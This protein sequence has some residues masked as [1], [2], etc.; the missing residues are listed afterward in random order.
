M[1]THVAK[2]PAGQPTV[3]GWPLG[4]RG[5]RPARFTGNFFAPETKDALGVPGVLTAKGFITCG[6]DA[7]PIVAK[8]LKVDAPV[9]RH[10]TVDDV[11]LMPGFARWKELGLGTKLRGYQKEGALFLAWRAFALNCD[12]M[13][14]GKSAQALGGVVLIASRKTLIV[15]PAIA[16]LGWGQEVWRWLGQEALLLEGRAG[17]IARQFCGVCKGRGRVEDGSYCA[18]CRLR[19]GTANGYRRFEVLDLEPVTSFEIYELPVEPKKQPE[20]EIVEEGEDAPKKSKRKKRALKTTRKTRV[21]YTPLPCKMA[22]KRHRDVE[23]MRADL[24]EQEL[25]QGVPCKKCQSELHNVIGAASFVVVNYELLLPQRTTDAQGKAYIREDLLGW[26]P[27]LAR[28]RFDACIADESHNLRGWS[29]QEARR[30]QTRR[31]KF[32]QVVENI[33]VVWGL[34]GT[35]IYGYVRDLWGQLDAI[36]KGLFGKEDRLPFDFHAAYCEGHKDEYGWKADG[37]SPRADVELEERLQMIRIQRPRSLILK[38]MPPKVRQVHYIE[39]EDGDIKP[40]GAIVGR[41]EAAISRLLKQTAEVKRDVVVENVISELAEGNKV[42]VFTLLREG[43]TKMAN[44]LDRAINSKEHRARMT[45]V[46][47][48]PVIL[49]HGDVSSETRFRMAEAFR[50]WEGAAVFVATIDA[51]QVAV[52]LAGA[53]SVHFADLHWQPAAMLQA[54]DRPY[55]PGGITRGL[56]IIYYIVK[57]SIDEHVEAIVL[58]K[59][60]TLARLSDEESAGSMSQ[61]FAGSKEENTAE[62]IIARLTAHLALEPSE[63]DAF[64]SGDSVDLG[65]SA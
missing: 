13:R 48:K 14:S 4:A 2:C 8:M 26:G 64:L 58:P 53:S 50:E 52:S 22:C 31:E 61:A 41:R 25:A 19:N 17:N 55:L 20:I 40:P 1:G 12:P 3:S 45:Q 60:E 42:V 27:V 36:T 37:R 54:E 62:A 47:V 21:L 33:P 39:P 10:P 34:T 43:A 46:K 28:F 9:P 6:W 24:S 32:N 38:D 59:V 30:G 16:K 63:E 35:P 15:P 49:A 29:S 11:V 18:S 56:N 23:V 44:A 57:G 5:V 51:V 65:E 7:A